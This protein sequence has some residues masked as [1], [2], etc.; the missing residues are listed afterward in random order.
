MRSDKYAHN[1]QAFE[2]AT[3]CVV[4]EEHVYLCAVDMHYSIDVKYPAFAN[5][6]VLEVGDNVRFCESFVGC[7]VELCCS[8][9]L[10]WVYVFNTSCVVCIQC[11][12][13]VLK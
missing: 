11:T 2:K 4:R 5:A 6:C 10:A 8:R 9:N 7:V 13:L 3:T 1:L 12:K